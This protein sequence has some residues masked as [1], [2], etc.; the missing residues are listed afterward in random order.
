LVL[1]G[2]DAI[3]D[4]A[5]T[6]ELVAA[7]AHDYQLEPEFANL[8]EVTRRHILF[9]RMVEDNWSLSDVYVI[10]VEGGEIVWVARY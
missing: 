8:P 6:L 9:G 4:D 10:M 2:S 5:R 3:K 7:E 1:D